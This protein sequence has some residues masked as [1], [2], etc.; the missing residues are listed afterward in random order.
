MNNIYNP[1]YELLSYAGVPF[2]VAVKA[3]A[4]HRL[5]HHTGLEFEEDISYVESVL[6]GGHEFVS[7][8]SEDVLQDLLVAYKQQQDTSF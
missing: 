8:L 6:V 3:I 5:D 7:L 2:M 4:V 1:H